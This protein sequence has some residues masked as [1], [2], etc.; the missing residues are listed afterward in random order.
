M[1]RRGRRRGLPRRWPQ[2]R[3]RYHIAVRNQQDCWPVD[4]DLCADLAGYVMA[5][6]AVP[7]G[8]ELSLSFV[9]VDQMAELNGA[10]MGQD[11][12][13]DVLA[14]PIDDFWQPARPRQAQLPQA[15]SRQARPQAGSPRA[16]LLVGEI[17]ICPP[18]AQRNAL[19]YAH[20]TNYG[21]TN[22]ENQA[23]DRTSAEIALLLAHGVLHLCGYDHG[24]PNE[25]DIMFKLQ[26]SYLTNFFSQSR[27]RRKP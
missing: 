6:E 15:G 7:R 10:H 18:I 1:L 2:R 24:D 13:T 27:G 9:D 16:P 8:S 4:D 5:G 23:L 25:R 3:G 17:V 21:Q 22:Y 14:F 20:K 26:Q 11:G 12:P 19:K